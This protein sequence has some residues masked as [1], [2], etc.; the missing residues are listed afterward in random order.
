MGAIYEVDLQ[1]FGR[2]VKSVHGFK[3]LRNEDLTISFGVVPIVESGHLDQSGLCQ[4]YFVRI[5]FVFDDADGYIEDNDFALF[6]YFF[7]HG[8]DDLPVV[9]QGICFFEPFP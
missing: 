5:L 4:G 8:R 2:Q 6:D 9:S 3:L 7:D 1:K